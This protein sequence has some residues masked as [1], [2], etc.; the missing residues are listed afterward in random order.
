METF[1]F[2]NNSPKND[3]QNTK[4]KVLESLKD[5][6]RPEFLNRLDDIIVFDILPQEVIRNIVDIVIKMHGNI[7]RFIRSITGNIDSRLL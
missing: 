7:T 1:G 2:S 6:F 5:H 4:D 3:Y